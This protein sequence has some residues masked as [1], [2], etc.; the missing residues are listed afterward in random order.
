[1]MRSV[2]ER[3]MPR[4]AL[5]CVASSDMLCC[6]SLFPLGIRAMSRRGKAM[7]REDLR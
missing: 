5:L 7:M 1:M 2:A 4:T 3:S 6:H